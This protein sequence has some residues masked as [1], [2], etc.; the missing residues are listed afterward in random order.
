[1][2]SHDVIGMI[3]GGVCHRRGVCHGKLTS[4]EIFIIP[5]IST[6]ITYILT[7][8]ALLPI[9]NEIQSTKRLL[10]DYKLQNKSCNLKFLL[11]ASAAAMVSHA[12][13]RHPCEF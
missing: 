1:M 13:D 4:L 2:M 10:N 3:G 8:C 5:H 6:K 7:L 9:F 12:N 11:L